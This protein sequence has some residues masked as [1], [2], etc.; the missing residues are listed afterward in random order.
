MRSNADADPPPDSPTSGQHAPGLCHGDRD[1]AVVSETDGRVCAQMGLIY[2]QG[3]AWKF[4]AETLA[5]LIVEF[6][7]CLVAIQK[8]Q[9]SLMGVLLLLQPCSLGRYVGFETGAAGPIFRLAFGGDPRLV[10]LPP[11]HLL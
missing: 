9:T 6:L 7:V 11:N 8:I 2:F 5:T 3:L 10:L 4:T 1:P